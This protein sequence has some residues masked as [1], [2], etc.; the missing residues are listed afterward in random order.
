MAF[1]PLEETPKLSD[2]TRVLVTPETE[3]EKMVKDATGVELP[4]GPQSM[5]LKLQE[6]F[7]AG[8]EPEVPEALRKGPT[9]ILAQL[10]KLLPLPPLPGIE[11]EEKPPAPPA[12]PTAVTPGYVLRDTAYPRGFALRK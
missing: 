5:V 10:P 4:Q 7:E 8:E 2:F 11:K 3:F 12:P 6:D 1:K 9:A